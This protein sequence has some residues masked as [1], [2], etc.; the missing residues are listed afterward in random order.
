MSM[1]TWLIIN[2]Y[3]DN[4][5]TE[6]EESRKH[7]FD[8]KF[9]NNKHHLSTLHIVLYSILVDFLAIALI[10]WSFLFYDLPVKVDESVVVIR[11]FVL[12]ES[13]DVNVNIVVAS[14]FVFVVERVQNVTP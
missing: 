8:R 7:W 10:T 3:C 9:E 4:Y 2:R 5:I 11:K 1:N 12:L 6:G 13:K 14:V